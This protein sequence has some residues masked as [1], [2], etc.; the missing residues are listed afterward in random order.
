MSAK[1]TPVRNVPKDVVVDDE[2]DFVLVSDPAADADADSDE[3]ESEGFTPTQSIVSDTLSES[4]T[5]PTAGEGAK[6]DKQVD[7][8]TE[9]QTEK[10]AAVEAAPDGSA[11]PDTFESF[12]S[13]ISP[14]VDDL[15]SKIDAN[16][17]YIPT[18]IEHYQNT[19][20]S[21][22]WGVTILQ[23][24]DRPPVGAIGGLAT[25][26]P[27]P[28]P[29]VQQQERPARQQPL[30]SSTAVRPF[31]WKSLICDG[32]DKHRFSG[33]R[34][35]CNVCNDFDFCEKCYSTR[36]IKQRHEHNA[37]EKHVDTSSLWVGST[38]DGCNKNSFSGAK[39]VCVECPNYDLCGKCYELCSTLHIPWHTLRPQFLP[40]VHS[41]LIKMGF[42]DK[43]R[44]QQ[45]LEDLNGD[46]ERVVAA[47]LA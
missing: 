31:V 40:A 3:K 5:I 27:S 32:C 15:I 21:R 44:N 23:P 2:E 42:T 19:L 6:F 33:P 47:L 7:G 10:S 12:L 13:S 39:W 35:K 37:F 43:Y 22:N 11:K 45:L 14:L 20:S 34:Y 28:L 46:I 24:D 29:T 41:K 25:H 18:L 9:A 17:Q 8:G 1:N 30:S 26:L 4:A 16:P 38:C 36:L